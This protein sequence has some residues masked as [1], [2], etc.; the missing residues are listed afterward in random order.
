MLYLYIKLLGNLNK[1]II[2]YLITNKLKPTTQNATMHPRS[3]SV[4]TQGLKMV[5]NAVIFQEH[6]IFFIRHY[7]TI[8]FA[9]N[10]KTGLTECNF[11]CSQ[12]SNRQIRSAIDFFNVESENIVDVSDGSKWAYS[13]EFTQ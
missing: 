7:S 11:N 1:Y 3:Q 4:G 13:G 8:I 9:H 12:T 2:G 6:G 10:P 5:K